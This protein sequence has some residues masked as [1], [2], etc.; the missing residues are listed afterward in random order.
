[1]EY[2]L[3]G[4]SGV[5]VSAVGLGA[6]NLGSPDVDDS[7]AK[8]IVHLALDAGVNLFDTANVYQGGRS[9][10]VLGA[11]LHGRRDSVILSTKVYNRVGPGPND[12]GLSAYH[13]HRECERSLRRLGVDHIDI[14]LLH[15]LDATVPAEETV[16]ALDDL[17]RS[18]KI[19]YW[20]TSAFPNSEDLAE[21]GSI[22]VVRS[23]EI[24]RLMNEAARRLAR[25]PVCDQMPYSLLEREVEQHLLPLCSQYGVGA[26]VYSPLAMG[27]LTERF[28]GQR[29]PAEA[30]FTSWFNGTSPLWGDTLSAVRQVSML[31]EEA[32]LTLPELAY[33]WAL[34]SPLV[35]SV[36]AGPRSTAHLQQALRAAEGP[37]LEGDLR[38]RLDGICQPGRSLWLRVA[39]QVHRHN[40]ASRRGEEARS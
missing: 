1:M 24:V 16:G 4:R 27:L 17:V 8:K 33:R 6:F 28:T 10:E 9:E 32:G 7:D 18:G 40:A 29:P 15:R 12:C 39:E 22:G 2:R 20:G 25:P 35:S 37:P 13:L 31:A 19:R 23:W 38:C 34:D 21:T 30:R 14:Y 3:L 11:A 36:L 5:R 26:I